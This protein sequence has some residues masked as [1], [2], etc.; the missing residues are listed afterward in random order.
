MN[1]KKQAYEY[2]KN[3]IITNRFRPET[4]IIEMEIASKLKM[5]RSPIREAMRELEMEGLIVSYPGHGSFVASISP[6]DVEEIYELRILLESWALKRSISRITSEELDNLEHNFKTAF[7]EG[8]W[9]ALHQADRAL[10]NLIINKSLSKRLIAFMNILNSQIERIRYISAKNK[11][12]AELS[13]HEHLKIIH[14]LRQHDFDKC[15]MTLK[16]HLKSVVQSAME[17]ARISKIETK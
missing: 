14:Y 1:R 12:R 2:L 10:H 7:R 5:S 15:K 17:V 8:D 16:T 6:Y 11:N 3:E 13:Y 9:E 4:P